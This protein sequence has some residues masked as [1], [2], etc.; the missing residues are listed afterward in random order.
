MGVQSCK[1]RR[2]TWEDAIF[3]DECDVLTSAG[4]ISNE[5]GIDKYEG[6]LLHN[7]RWEHDYEFTAKSIAIIGCGSS[8]IQILPI[9]AKAS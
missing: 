3:E 7:A 8:A 9:F 1:N 2:Q 5:K 4:R 6:K